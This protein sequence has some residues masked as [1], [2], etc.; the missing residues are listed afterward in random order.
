M[1]GVP[2][3]YVDVA[4]A[5]TIRGAV[6]IVGGNGV[7]GTRSFHGN[8][9]EFALGKMTEEL[10]KFGLHFAHVVGVEV[11]DLLAGSGVEAAVVFDVIVQGGESIESEL[12]GEGEHLGFGFVH[13]L[14]A[15]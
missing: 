12:V 5:R 9:Y 8:D 7:F 4:W 13:L 1:F 6:G 14:K 10:G 15:D 11:E 3:V 2:F